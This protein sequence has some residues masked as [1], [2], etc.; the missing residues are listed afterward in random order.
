MVLCFVLRAPDATRLLLQD[1]RRRLYRM[2]PLL[3]TKVPS[4][5]LCSY[6]DP[7]SAL[8]SKG[9]YIPEGH[10]ALRVES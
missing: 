9:L 10:D 2:T 8:R 6:K 5:V 1:Y 3:C 7:K 4:G